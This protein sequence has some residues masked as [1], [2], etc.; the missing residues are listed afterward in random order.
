MR[1]VRMACGSSM[2]SVDDQVLVSQVARLRRDGSDTQDIEAKR[3]ADDLPRDLRKTV[4]AFANTNGGTIILGLDESR[5]FAATGVSDAVRIRDALGSMCATEMTPAV[6]PAFL[7]I[8]E[9][10]D[11]RLV[12]AQIDP[13]PVVDRPCFVSAQGMDKGSYTRSADG[14]RHLTTYEISTMVSER[15]QPRDDEK[16]VDGATIADLDGESVRLLLSR[17]RD[18]S[19]HAYPPSLD[20][21]VA[22]QR[23][24]V[25]T[26][27]PSPVPTRAGLLALGGYPQQFFPKVSVTFVHYPTVD[28][29]QTERGQRFEDN[30]RIEGSIPMM[31]QQTMAVLRNNMVRRA[32][33]SGSGR[34]EAYEYPEL[35]LREA[36]VNALIHRDLKDS[37]LGTQVQVEMYPDRIVITNPGG[38]YGPVTIEQLTKGTTPSSSR[39]ARLVTLL[40]DVVIPGEDRAICENRGTGIRTMQQAMA[41]A[42]M[43]PPELRDDGTVFRV[44]IPNHALLDDETIEWITSLGLHRL[45]DSQHTALAML[46]DGKTLTNS[47]YRRQCHLDST[48]ARSELNDLVAR[49]VVERTGATSSTTYRL[50]MR[51][52]GAAGR[53][54]P[55]DWREPILR[56]IGRRSATRRE[57]EEVT[58]LKA[59]NARAWLRRL[60]DEGKIEIEGKPTSNSARYR[61]LPPFFDEAPE[62]LEMFS[63]DSD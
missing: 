58:G 6:R 28:G 34:A 41:N 3:S 14:D 20:D 56:F 52:S 26:V 51:P 62:Q 5:G 24:G 44:T 15:G 49:G 10:E 63:F 32:Y 25:L 23:L 16:A 4:S 8:C 47:T 55:K 19:P 38:L 18:Q 43:S 59:S 46:R 45:T 31:A 29:R 42:G 2:H 13:I 36:V 60:Q 53:P 61:A 27:D 39:N 48:V 12:V 1:F 30:Q 11:V 33:I 54:S 40:E 9:F 22:L 37:A 57:I 17:L 35:A 7:D 21:K 50:A